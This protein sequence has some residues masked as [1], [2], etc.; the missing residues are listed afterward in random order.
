MMYHPF[1]DKKPI[2]GVKTQYWR[3]LCV[4]FNVKFASFFKFYLLGIDFFYQNLFLVLSSFNSYKNGIEKGI[5]ISF[6]FLDFI[7]LDE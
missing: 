6:I 7:H 4:Y 3:G 2:M 1:H 5:G